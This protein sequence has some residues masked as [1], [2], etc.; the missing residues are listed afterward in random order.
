MKTLRP[1]KNIKRRL[2][3]VSLIVLITAVAGTWTL[4]QALDKPV[5]MAVAGDPVVP[6][7][8]VPL[9]QDVP[10]E[11]VN[12]FQFIKNKPE[13][14]KLGKA[15]F[16]DMQV[17]SD[18]IQACASCHFSAGADNRVKNTIHPGPDGVFQAA[19]APNE[20]VPPGAFPF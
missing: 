11:P 2:L 13:A 14:I 18:G 1:F 20:T 8:M 6:P 3:P 5:R 7:D 19:A 12:L 10:D 15:F 16:W 9:N 4:G 17:G